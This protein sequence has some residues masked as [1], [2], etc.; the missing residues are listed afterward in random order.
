MN[1]KA[2]M[3]WLLYPLIGPPIGLIVFNTIQ[4]NWPSGVG[5]WLAS[6]I[7]GG[8]SAAFVGICAGAYGAWRGNVPL[9]VPAVAAV[10]PPVAHT[11][12]NFEKLQQRGPLAD[13]LWFQFALYLVPA[14]VVW[15]II[16]VAWGPGN[17]WTPK[18]T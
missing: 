10:V 9:W 4:G 8:F 7:W 11:L 1:S 6:Y 5:I 17:P 13:P 12:Y 18:T 14:I 16:R 3:T 2:G 15:F